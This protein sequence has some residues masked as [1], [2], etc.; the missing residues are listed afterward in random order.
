MN[1][2][3]LDLP[4]L[5]SWLWDAACSIRVAIDALKYKECIL[6]LL[7]HKRFSDVYADE[8]AR[9]A[10]EIGDPALA[11]ELAAQDRNPVDYVLC[12]ELLHRKVPDHTQSWQLLMGI[13][14]PDWRERERRLAA[15]MLKERDDETR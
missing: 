12:H 4:T 7:F 10:R 5:E 6:P 9:I 8:I 11:R 13:H 14:L 2:Q 1:S 15:W 3:T